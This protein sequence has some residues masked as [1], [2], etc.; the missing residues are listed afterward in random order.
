MTMDVVFDDTPLLNEIAR[1]QAALQS[2]CD[3]RARSEIAA[4]LRD[5]QLKLD[6]LRDERRRTP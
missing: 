5:E 3:V 2:A 4:R 6:R 1:L